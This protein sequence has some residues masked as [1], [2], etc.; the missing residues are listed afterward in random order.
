MTE[1]PAAADNSPARNGLTPCIECG[2]LVLV[3]GIAVHIEMG[4]VRGVRCPTCS[5]TSDGRVELFTEDV[6]KP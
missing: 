1:I 6:G 3:G 5:G 2:A 4:I